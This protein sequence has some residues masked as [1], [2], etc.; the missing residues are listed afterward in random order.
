M[1]RNLAVIAAG[2]VIA[3]ALVAVIRVATRRHRTVP[4][5]VRFSTLLYPKFQ[6]KGCTKCHDFYEQRLGGLAYTSHWT[7]TAE[8]C[9]ECHDTQVTGFVRPSEWFA[10]PGVY[11]SDMNAA[12]TCETIKRDLHGGFKHPGK[13][14]RDIADHLFGSPRVLWGIEGATARS[15]QLPEGRSEPDLVQGGL[16]QWKRDVNDWLQGGMDCN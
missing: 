5:D 1:N 12:Q 14:A 9:G 6:A 2:A 3:L 11:T 8:R 10:R 4:S 13:L 7:L 15:G 16:K